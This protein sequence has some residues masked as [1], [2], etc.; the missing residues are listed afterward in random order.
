MLPAQLGGAVPPSVHLADNLKFEFPAVIPS[1]PLG[2]FA[3]RSAYSLMRAKCLA[4]WSC[5]VASLQTRV[6]PDGS[7]SAAETWLPQGN[8][9]GGAA[10]G[11]TRLGTI[12]P[13]LERA[14]YALWQDKLMAAGL[15]VGA[16]K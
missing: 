7:A 16:G 8:A 6:R 2:S 10:T 1:W 5:S 14:E 12:T 15:S 9:A 11:F 13:E 4:L 3:V